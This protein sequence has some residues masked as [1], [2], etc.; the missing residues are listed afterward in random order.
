MRDFRFGFNFSGLR[1]ASEVADL[2]RTAEELGYDIA[3]GTDHLP[4]GS[5]FSPLAIAAHATSRMR[6]GTLTINNEF[7]NPAM[8]AR[9]AITLD[10]LTDGRFEL[11][12][13]A[14]HMKWE[15]DAAGLPW[16]PIGERI[17]RLGRTVEELRRLFT[18]GPGEPES[19][20][21]VRN[22]FGRRELKPVQKDGLHASGPPLL[23]GGTGDRV[24]SLAAQHADIVGIGGLFQVKGEPPGTFRMTT[25]AIAEERVTFIREQAGD[26]A[27]GVEFNV[28]VQ[29]V[30][31]TDDRRGLAE[32]LV[33]ERAPYLTVDEA[34]ETP[35]VLIGTAE[36][37]A[38][39]LRENRERF[40]FSYI[41]VHEPYMREFAPVIE[42]LS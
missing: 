14:G 4:N 22:R 40:G 15:F 42:K 1:P 7:W 11:G 2:C 39:Q 31:I 20:V 37:I 26:R 18:D 28:L 25:A 5:P 19:A 38:E 13:G 16:R 29:F 35:F 9:E 41:V 12:L 34:L 6:V 32:N 33:A 23:I 24:L 10:Y 27:N 8:L 36:Q 30:A 17:E 3:L 21:Q